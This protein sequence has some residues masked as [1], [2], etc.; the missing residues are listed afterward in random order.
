M[1]MAAELA[2]AYDA[3]LLIV[4][5]MELWDKRYDFL[6]TDLERKLTDEAKGRVAQELAHLGK[7][8][9][10]PVE[11]L[12]RQ[13]PIVEQVIKV[14]LERKPLMLVVG[15]NS[16]PKPD[17]THLGGMAQELIRLSP[18]SVVITRPTSSPD[19]KRILCAVGGGPDSST[20]LEWALDLAKR[21]R[22]GEIG[23]INTFAVPTGYLEAG[24][25]YEGARDKMQQLHQSDM[26]KLT[27]PHANSPIKIRSV[28]EEGPVPETVARLAKEQNADLLVVGSESRSFLA[29]LLLG[30]MGLQVAGQTRVPVALV[31]SKAHRLG[32]LAALERL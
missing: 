13:G 32:L 12:I 18:V 22:V 19:I 10:V 7:T 23:L 30:R 31:K 2:E 27:A 1:A 26:D 4:H 9:A 8:E 3:R 11:V 21:E 15:C 17:E 20:T 14:V 24:M 6:V 28:V 16:S 29:A 25:T 5:A